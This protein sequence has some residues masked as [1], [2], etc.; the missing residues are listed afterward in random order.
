MFRMTESWKDAL[1]AVR[2]VVAYGLLSLSLV[3]ALSWVAYFAGLP[4]VI[5]SYV[6]LAAGLVLHP[7]D[8]RPGLARRCVLLIAGPLT[9]VLIVC[10]AAA[11]SRGRRSIFVQQLRRGGESAP[12]TWLVAAL[13]LAAWGGFFASLPLIRSWS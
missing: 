4:L 3:G 10:G 2:Y 7:W 13:N 9:A 1:G 11:R 5:A 8:D 12:R 6:L